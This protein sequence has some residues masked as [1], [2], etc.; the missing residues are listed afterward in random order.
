MAED[1]DFRDRVQR[2]GDLVQQIEEIADPATRATA[3]G[4]I[5]SL[6]DLHGAAI[7]RTMEIVAEAGDPGVALIDQL[8]RDPMVSSLL[9]LYGL[10]PEDLDSR[11]QKAIEKVKPQLRKQGAE[12]EILELHEGVVRLRV[13]TGEHTCG[14]TAKT[15]RTTLEGAIYDAAPDLHLLTL[16]GLDGQIASGFVSLDKIAAM[17]PPVLAATPLSLESGD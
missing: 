6:M 8:G 10:H 17:V 2:I 5:Q 3:K 14:S 1:K 7:E 16:E 15:V 12:V 4:L 9:V 11:V 13:Q